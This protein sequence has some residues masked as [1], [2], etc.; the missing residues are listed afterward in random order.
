MAVQTELESVR[1]DNVNLYEKIKFVQSYSPPTKPAT[2]ARHETNIVIPD[3]P[4]PST[5]REDELLAR[6]SHAYEARLNPFEQFG[7]EERSRRYQALQ[8]HEKLMHSLVS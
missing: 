5:S 4:K 6:Y 8:P 2:A 3:P 1:K 7:R